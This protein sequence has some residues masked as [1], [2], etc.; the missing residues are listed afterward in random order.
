MSYLILFASLAFI[1]MNIHCL[2]ELI[3]K[4]TVDLRAKTNDHKRQTRSLV[5]SSDIASLWTVTH[6]DGYCVWICCS[7]SHIV[8]VPV[9]VRQFI[10][11][12]EK[13]G[14]STYL[15]LY[16][17]LIVVRATYQDGNIVGTNYLVIWGVICIWYLG[18]GIWLS[19]E[20][21]VFVT[22]SIYLLTEHW[23]V[24]ICISVPPS[25]SGIKM[26]NSF[27]C[28]VLENISKQHKCKASWCQGRKLCF[29]KK[30]KHDMIRF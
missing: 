1:P 9:F 21:F 30:G 15:T 29:E 3:W 8:F 16:L 27:E 2:Y 23:S 22:N 17:H 11:I 28:F 10:C 6:Q 13:L 26:W 18:A 4:R 20:S 14:Q 12:C 24:C 25:L 5:H 7:Y 19:E